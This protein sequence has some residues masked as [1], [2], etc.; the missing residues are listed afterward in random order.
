[1]PLSM[2]EVQAAQANEFADDLPILPEMLSWS[3]YDVE[4]YFRSGGT[5]KPQSTERSNPPTTV[6]PAAATGPTASVEGKDKRPRLLGLHGSNSNAEATMFQM[7]ILGLSDFEPADGPYHCTFL[8]APLRAGKF[9][10]GLKTEAWS[11]HVQ[12]QSLDIGLKK[13]IQHCEEM[14][15]YDGVYGFSQGTSMLTLLT[16]REIWLAYGGSE[17]CFPPWRFVV[18]GCG[19][20][21]LLDQADVPA[22]TSDN[23]LHVPSL[24]IMGSKDEIRPASLSLSKRY[25]SPD[26]VEHPEGHAIPISLSTPGDPI[27]AKV[28]SFVKEHLGR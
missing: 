1:M 2:E 6:Q 12:G 27:I 17:A 28:A 22:P 8:E 24:H 9:D 11:W 23:P 7:I 16:S 13:I 15:P 14:G 10:D 21:Y 4:N 19:T 18:C 5:N 20:D 26:I 25:A 3:L